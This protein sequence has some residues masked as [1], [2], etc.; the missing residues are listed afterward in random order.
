MTLTQL[1]I[2]SRVAELQGFTS[3]ATRLGISQSAVSHAIRALEQE[4]GVELFHR[5]QAQVELT[6]IGQQLLTRARGM[7]GLAATLEQEAADARGMK[8]GTLR[9]GSFGPSSS[10]RLLPP[11]LA[12]FRS[13][14]PGIEVHI[15]EGP[16]RQVLQWLEERRIDLGFVVQPQER[17]DTFALAEDQLVALLPAEHPLAQEPQV[18]LEQLC[19]DPFV[20]T[21][22][23]SSELVS[24]LFIGAGLKPNIRY[25][26]SQLLSTLETVARGDA[27]SIVAQFSLP[28]GTD[29]RYTNRP[30]EPTV[31]RR[32]AIAVLD[33]RQSSP[34]TL[35]FIDLAQRLYGQAKPSILR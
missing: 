14:Y 9:I 2:F 24:R 17:F 18:R 22:A 21:E 4:L 6:D 1:E 26:C 25:R 33:R 16:D 10:I 28:Q 20:L 12:Q 11:I 23:G 35:A 31:Q 3:A 30:L 27:L 8:R 15:D 34:A 29:P 13:Q 5:H 32:I 7:L 19:N